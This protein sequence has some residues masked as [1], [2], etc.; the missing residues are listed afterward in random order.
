MT[1]LEEVRA[2]KA[3]FAEMTQTKGAGY[4]LIG[5]ARD[6][7]D[8]YRALPAAEQQ[9][10]AAWVR[11]FSDLDL[12]IS[13]EQTSYYVQIAV[14]KKGLR[15]ANFE[16]LKRYTSEDI[17]GTEEEED[18]YIFNIWKSEWPYIQG[19]LKQFEISYRLMTQPQELNQP[20]IP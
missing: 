12:F 7:R 16:H 10:L 9:E 6:L 2:I 8:L 17:G 18:E 1:K 19:F 4:K 11:S 13:S 14:Q 20:Q 3:R 15:A 5:A